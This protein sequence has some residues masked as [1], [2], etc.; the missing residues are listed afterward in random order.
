VEIIGSLPST[1]LKQHL[2]QTYVYQ[3]NQEDGGVILPIDSIGLV[4]LPTFTVKI[5][6]SCRQIYNRPMD[7]SWVKL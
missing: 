3:E 7:P 6:H 5:N 1:K 2:W 4:Y